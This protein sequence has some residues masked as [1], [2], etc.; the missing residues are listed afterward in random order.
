MLKV[1]YHAVK[2]VELQ[3][4][5]GSIQYAVSII[6]LVMNTFAFLTYLS[7]SSRSPTRP[8]EPPA[9][10]AAAA[11]SSRVRPCSPPANYSGSS[12]RL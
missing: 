11:P 10:I 2:E 6:G 7:P 5:L 9:T 8:P 1:S 4:F 3:C 12:S